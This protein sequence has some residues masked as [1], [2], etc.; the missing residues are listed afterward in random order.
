MFVDKKTKNLVGIDEFIDSE[1][2]LE[3]SGKWYQR[4]EREKEWEREG[5][6]GILERGIFG[7]ARKD[8]MKA[9]FLADVSKHLKGVGGLVEKF[10]DPMGI[11]SNFA[12]T[13]TNT[14]WEASADWLT[15]NNILLVGLMHFQDL[16]NFDINRVN[17]CLVH[18]G[19][20]D[21]ATDSVRQV[22][23]CAMNAIHRERIEDELEA[24]N[25][26]VQYVPEIKTPE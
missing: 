22:P 13:I 4:I 17:H 18:Y 10:S 24:G 21:P 6:V 12:R 7:K 2:F 19:Y 8:V 9:R 11:I 3:T 26:M 20:I 5:R 25:K 23:F 16:Y 14:S 15:A 1:K